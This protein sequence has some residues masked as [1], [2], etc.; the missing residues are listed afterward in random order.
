MYLLP[1]YTIFLLRMWSYIY[2][3]CSARFRIQVLIRSDCTCKLSH[4]SELTLRKC[5][6][7][8][9]NK[10]GHLPISADSS[11]FRLGPKRRRGYKICEDLIHTLPTLFFFLS[12]HL[13]KSIG[14]LS[15]LLYGRS[16]TLLVPGCMDRLC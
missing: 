9:T 13:D 4:L 2:N 5:S 14:W 6:N 15:F 1:L 7:P 10:I 3:C 11:K 8:H 12:P 16:L